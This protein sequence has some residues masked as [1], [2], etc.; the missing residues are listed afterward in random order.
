M[1]NQSWC[2]PWK[3]KKPFPRGGDLHYCQS[4]LASIEIQRCTCMPRPC[5]AWHPTAIHACRSQYICI[6]PVRI[7]WKC[8]ASDDDT[9][10]VVWHFRLPCRPQSSLPFGHRNFHPRWR[11]RRWGSLRSMLPTQERGQWDHKTT[12]LSQCSLQFRPRWLRDRCRMLTLRTC[13]EATQSATFSLQRALWCT[14]TR[15]H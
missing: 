13:P 9:F 7:R 5:S 1:S 11:W 10:K 3:L 12:L 15:K 8:K 6:R 2:R 4:A 14:K